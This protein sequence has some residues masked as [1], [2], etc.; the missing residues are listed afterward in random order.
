MNKR[1]WEI[2]FL[3]GIA[4]LMMVIFHFLWD[5]NYF[6]YANINLSSG[7]GKIFQVTTASLFLF[8][9]GISTYLSFMREKSSFNAFLKRGVKIFSFGVLITLITYI[10]YPSEYIIFGI[11]HLIGVSVIFSYFF[12]KFKYLNLLFGFL[13]IIIGLVL[14][15]HLFNFSFLLPFGFTP[16]DYGALDYY[17]IF[18]WFGVVLFGIFFSK[19]FYKNGERLFTFRFSDNSKI[20]QGIE[21][22]GRKSLLVYLVHQP[23]LFLAFYIF[24]IAAKS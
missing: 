13:F 20:I 3:R 12:I 18:P 5:L 10:L 11:L 8:L 7:L 9:V 1:L 19:S 17:P 2:D 14:N 16:H 4:I 21:A 23:V 22:I 24:K 6:G 15:N